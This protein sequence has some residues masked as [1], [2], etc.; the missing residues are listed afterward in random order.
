MGEASPTW[1]AS[2][3][4]RSPCSHYL[5]PLLAHAAH[6]KNAAAEAIHRY[7]EID[8]SDAPV[9]EQLSA[10]AALHQDLIDL[11]QRLMVKWPD[12]DGD[13]EAHSALNRAIE[14]ARQGADAL[15]EKGIPDESAKAQTSPAAATH[16][17]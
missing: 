3:R 15:V 14:R 5:H 8:G 11:A 4:K 9:I 7:G 16:P 12:L 1:P 10:Y 6:L 2:F 13:M 17:L